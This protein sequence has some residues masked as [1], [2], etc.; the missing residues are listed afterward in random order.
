MDRSKITSWDARRD[1]VVP[2]D[3]EATIQFCTEHW[4]KVCNQSIDDHGAFYVA[5]SGGST[6]KAIFQKLTSP[7][8]AH[9]ID[10]SKVHLFW[11][12]ERTVPPDH[13]DSN[14]HMALTAGL[15][16]M[17]IAKNHIHRMQA[18]KDIDA[19][20][21][22]YE[23]LIHSVL[24]NRPFDLVMLGMGEDGHTASLFPHTKALAET[25]RLV[26]ANYIEDKK[27]WR[28]TFTYHCINQAGHIAIYVIG[29]AKKHMLKEVLCALDQ[30]D[31]LPSQGVG[32]KEH[33]ALWIADAAAA[34]EIPK[35]VH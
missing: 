1:L 4:L 16:K 30:F 15:E 14:Y 19:H 29:D 2:G 9:H 3:A 28:M 32:T 35:N 31:R 8:Y 13:P 12:D 7:L 23:V 26:V 25:Q 11:S 27:T 20:A 24:K 33:R 34:S 10:W 6:P 21:H 18:E 22:A 5:L 17:A